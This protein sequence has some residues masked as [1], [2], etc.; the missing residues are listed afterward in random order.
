M[1][2]LNIEQSGDLY[3]SGEAVDLAQSPGRIVMLTAADSEISLM[4]AAARARG[5]G[6][7]DLRL[8]NLLALNHPFSVDIYVEKTLTQ[9]QLILVR[10]LGGVGYWAYG[11]EQLSRL[12]QE[13][14]IHLAMIA[15]DGRPDAE[16]AKYSTLPPEILAQLA[17]YLDHGGLDNAEA[18][19]M[20]LDDIIADTNTAPPPRPL[21]KAGL[22]WHDARVV[23]F[24]DMEAIWRGENLNEDAPIAAV[25]CYRALMQGGRCAP[26]DALISALTARGIRALPLYAASLKDAESSAVIASLLRQADA[27]V[28]INATSF[29]VSDPAS[30]ANMDAHSEKSSSSQSPGAFGVVDAPVIQIML[31][32]STQAQWQDSLAGLTPR[33]LAMNVVLP[34]LDGRIIS[35]AIGFKTLPKR[36][37]LTEAMT[38][39][40]EAHQGRCAWVAELAENWL[41]LRAKPPEEKR[42]ALVLANYPNRDGRLANGVGLDTPASALVVL[43]ALAAAGYVVGDLPDDTETLMQTISTRPTNSGIAG[44][45]VDAWLPLADYERHFADLPKPTQTLIRARWGDAKSDPMLGEMADGGLGFALPVVMQGQVALAIQPA[46]GYNIDP[47]ASYHSPDLPPPHHYLA[48]YFWCRHH[49]QADAMISLGKHGNLEWLPGKALALDAECLPE[50]CGGAMPHF[51]PFIVNDPGEGSQAKRRSAAVILDH[52]T[53]P[54][55]LADSHGVMAELEASMDEYYEAVGVDKRRGALLMEDI[56]AQAE[57]AGLAQDCGIVASDSMDE[58]L[59]KL[60]NFLCDIKE[61]QIRDGLHIFGQMMD[62]P[63]FVDLLVAI[64]RIPRGDGE[65]ANQSLLRALARDILGDAEF[66]PLTCTRAQTWQGARPSVLAEMDDAKWRSQGDTAERLHRLA[67][68]LVADERTAAK[69]WKQTHL[70]L[71]HALPA[72]RQAISQSPLDE[73]RFLLRGL[74]GKYVPAGASGAPTRGK[75]EVLPTGRNFFSVDTRAVPT[76]AAW[77]IGWASAGALIDRYVQDHGNYPQSMVLSVWGTANMRTGGDDLAQALA[78]MGVQPKWE[79]ASRRVIGFDIMPVSVLGRPRVDI[80]LRASGFFRDAF[81]SQMTLFD[82]AVRAVAAL[83]EKPED[84]PLAANYRRERTECIN[85]GMRDEDATRTAGFRIFSTPPGSYG[86]GMQTLI[87][88][89]LWQSR[90]DFAEVFLT[91]GS[92]AYGEAESGVAAQGAFTRRLQSIDAVLHNQ[93]NREH[94]ILDSDDYYQF[95]G[96]LGATIA[97]L[98]GEDVPIYLGDHALGD[99]PRVRSLGEEISRIIRGRASNPKW[100][101]GVMRHGYKGAFEMAA[102]LDY[103]FAFAATTRQVED[104]HFDALFDGWMAEVP[105]AEFI[106][107]HNPAAWDEMLKRFQEAVD[108][109]LWH[110]RRNMTR[111]TLAQYQKNRHNAP[112]MTNA[113]PNHRG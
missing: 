43:R 90:A 28:I 109:G 44:R 8:A 49:H 7:G 91:W 67:R 34:E 79:T 65:G 31:S 84:N 62:A 2:L 3:T 63:Q 82:K 38:S 85:A 77:R 105:V 58:K 76:P 64:L 103:L 80:T 87:D 59:F 68:Q 75:V 4:A 54:M 92:Y 41:N 51:Y 56:L 17:A 57:R 40:Y 81:P 46:R 73:V 36:D 26:M 6:A 20:A 55:T 106:Q 9:A 52:L 53:P 99:A 71:K 39:D 66:D 107:K 96:G 110:P 74:A 25:V 33:D 12:A 13:K 22:Y 1:H 60:D 11:V 93:D 32:A 50:I 16:L 86:A 69:T 113:T 88:E 23:D 70:V 24:T 15:G 108:R 29:A 94:D 95:A 19:L 35:R 10:L 5:L 61:M 27:G 14:N 42:L 21:L 78:L 30:P 83:D 72:L 112:A 18:L 102:T 104:H 45:N 98:K 97:T 89:G 47:K 111:E 48:F 100:I 37:P 101:S